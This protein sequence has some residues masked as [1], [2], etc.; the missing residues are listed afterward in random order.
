MPQFRQNRV[1]KHYVSKF[2]EKHNMKYNEKSFIEANYD[3]YKNLKAVAK[4]N[5]KI[6]N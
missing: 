1:G 4:S 2:F 6:K 5:L 3:V